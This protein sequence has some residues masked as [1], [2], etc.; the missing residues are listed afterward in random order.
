[1]INQAA[2]FTALVGQEFVDEEGVI[3]GRGIP[4]ALI[5]V[6]PSA[7]VMVTGVNL[8]PSDET[9][10]VH[11]TLTCLALGVFTVDLDSSGLQRT[12]TLPE[13]VAPDPAATTTTV[14]PTTVPAAPGVTT[15]I[16]TTTTRARP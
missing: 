3:Q 10:F 4:A 14:P 8:A 13:C 15:T 16:R 11:F 7:G 12:I 2:P 1:M 5:R 9:G 6:L